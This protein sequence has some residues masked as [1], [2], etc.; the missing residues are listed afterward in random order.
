[1]L[2]L[3]ELQQAFAS[4]LRSPPGQAPA[5][6][7]PAAL[8]DHG[9]AVDDRLAVYKNNVYARLIDALAASYPAVERLVGAEFFRYAA[10]EYIGRNLPRSPS[11]IGYGRHFPAFLAHFAPA[12]SVPYLADVATLEWHYL[13]AYHAAEATPAAADSFAAALADPAQA[14]AFQ[15]HPSARLMQSSFPVSRIWELNVQPEPPSE[16]HRIPGEA[17]WL[18][19]VRPQAV[20]EVRRIARGAYT[21]L[22]A[23]EDGAGIAAALSTGERAEPGIDLHRHLMALAAGESFCLREPQ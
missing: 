19:I 15:L 11:L 21:A 22:R 4:F 16:K 1:M 18:L 13:E 3:A 17:E 9:A 12:A 5:A 2:P 7:L 23:I 20:V 6:A 8:R 14:P 10:I